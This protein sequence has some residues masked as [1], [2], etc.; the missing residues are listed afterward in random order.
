[1]RIVI[2]HVNGFDD[3]DNAESYTFHEHSLTV[4]VE[5]D[6]IYYSPHYWQQFVIDPKQEDP[7]NRHD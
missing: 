2:R 5:G 3:W 1:M 6:K 7:L 4:T